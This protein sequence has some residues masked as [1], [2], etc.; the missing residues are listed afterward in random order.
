MKINSTFC[1]ISLTASIIMYNFA[2][3]KSSTPGG[4]S[5][6]PCAGKNITVDNT[7]TASSVCGST[8]S[9]V[10]NAAGS[11]GFTYKLN[12]SGTYQSSNVFNNIGA[13]TYTVFVK[14]AVGC[15]RSASATIGGSGS[16]PFTVTIS[17]SPAGN[18]GGTD[19]SITINAT[20]SSGFS[21]KLN[22]GAYQASNIFTNLGAGS[23]SVTVK[24]LNGCEVTTAANV[25]VN[26][27]PGP[28][29]GAVKSV[30][31]ANCAGSGCHTNGGNQGGRN[32]DVDCNIV[33]AKVRINQRAVIEGSMPA[34]GPLS[35]ANKAIITDWINAGGG[36]NN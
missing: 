22:S 9:I 31:Q 13:A 24:D 35:A 26:T 21:Y 15:E 23:N 14:D 10:V 30:I 33:A 11:S 20:G 16:A 29:F 36:F 6:D 5:A 3:S 8:G 27:T 12:S 1:I 7:V 2:C 4:T 19:G 25:S 28:K 18:C 34:L 17:T 32:F